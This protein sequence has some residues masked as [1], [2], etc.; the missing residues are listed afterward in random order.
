[1]NPVVRI[2]PSPTGN[3]HIGT[4]RTALFNFLFAR[5]TK[6][7][8]IVRIEDT[9][10]E[11]SKP[12]F[13]KNILD[14]FA[15]LGLVQDDFFR[16][17]ERVEIYKTFLKKLIE[18]GAA[19][20]SKEEIKKEGDREEVIRFKNPNKKISFN[21]IIRGEVI[22]DTTELGD[23]VIARS[24]SEPL[25]H[26]AVVI[27]DFEMGITHVLRG[28]DHIS[29]TPRQ[30]LI[31]EAIGAPR[32]IYG[33]IPLIL[34]RDRSKLSKR[35]GATSIAEFRAKGY[36]P[37]AMINYLAL[38]GWNPGGEQ[39]IFTL[40]ELTA[41]FDITKV[42]KGG[43]IFDEEKLD[44]VNKEHIKRL[45]HDAMKAQIFSQITDNPRSKDNNWKV[46]NEIIS[47]LLS[48][49]I[50]RISKWGD[51]DDMLQGGEL[52]FFFSKPIY[53]KKSLLWKDEKDFM[54]VE[55]HIEE[56]IKKI[57][58]I[59][60]GNWKTESIKEALWD[61]ATKEGRGSVLWP[62][63][64]ALSGR[65]KSPD[66]FILASILRKKETIARLTEAKEILKR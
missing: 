64:Y 54:N 59:D 60:E 12:E 27:D 45:P 42:Q 2:A 30:I 14:G 21:D 10:K 31:G 55:R 33:H 18:S 8:F 24:E 58:S 38:L 46:T 61:Y 66:P 56:V 37:E 15:W 62:M 1:M 48:I 11:R 39:E 57:E 53:E 17:S 16:Q 22:F 40:E 43:A 13:E 23:F 6:G 47:E 25:Y 50:E 32:P 41:V 35:H 19:Y 9:D 63:R 20:I 51:L 65:E 7:K 49:I 4:T 36:L 34:G 52:D 5:H 44:W 3:L 26:L 29:N 28:E